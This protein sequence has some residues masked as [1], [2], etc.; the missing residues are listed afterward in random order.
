MESHLWSTVKNGDASGEI[1]PCEIRI[2]LLEW[3][4]ELHKRA[5]FVFIVRKLSKA[6]LEHLLSNCC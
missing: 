4:M 5:S 2:K 1:L 6:V 3:S